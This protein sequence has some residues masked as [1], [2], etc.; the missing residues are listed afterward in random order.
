MKSSDENLWPRKTNRDIGFDEVSPLDVCLLNSDNSMSRSK[1]GAKER[2]NQ[3]KS[4]IVAAS[5]ELNLVGLLSF[6]LLG[7]IFKAQVLTLYNFI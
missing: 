1:K 2:I 6:A 5:S 4:C 3:I 7:N